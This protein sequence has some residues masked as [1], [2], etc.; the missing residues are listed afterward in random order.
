MDA[1]SASNGDLPAMANATIINATTNTGKA[2]QLPIATPKLLSPLVTTNSKRNQMTHQ[3]FDTQKLTN[4]C[5]CNCS[6]TAQNKRSANNERI[7]FNANSCDLI[8]CIQ[9][10]SFSCDS[11]SKSYFV[12]LADPYS[13]TGVGHGDDD[14]EY[15]DDN[16]DDDALKRKPN[17]SPQPLSML[18]I[19][20][21]L[22]ATATTPGSA[23]GAISPV[24]SLSKSETNI[25]ESNI[26]D[27][28]NQLFYNVVSLNNLHDDTEP[29]FNRTLTDISKN[30]CLTTSDE[31]DLY[32]LSPKTLT[33]PKVLTTVTV[34][35]RN[36][37]DV[38]DKVF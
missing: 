15:N 22:D 17:L 23:N 32:G 1:P 33:S 38:S 11:I 26:E 36:A 2:L 9:K 8:H 3:Q 37:A 21:N 10:E 16:D 28:R 14:Y 24:I 30:Q 6:S 27:N 13:Q 20:T 18:G 7:I 19:N 12:P 34:S 31:N 25:A 35:M 29:F 5:K 4:K